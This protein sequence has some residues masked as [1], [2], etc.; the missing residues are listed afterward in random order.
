MEKVLVIWVL[1]FIGGQ[2][3]FFFR[4]KVKQVKNG[5]LGSPNPFKKSILFTFPQKK[6]ELWGLEIFNSGGVKVFTKKGFKANQFFWDGRNN[7]GN[8]LPQ[9]HYLIRAESKKQTFSKSVKKI[10]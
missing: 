2:L 5:L 10:E 6:Q 8:R 4:T 7:F 1:K 9:G 3:I